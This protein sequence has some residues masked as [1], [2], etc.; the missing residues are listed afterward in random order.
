MKERN[1][2][3]SASDNS[4]PTQVRRL[5]FQCARCGYGAVSAAAPRRC[6]MCEEDVWDL[7][8]RRLFAAARPFNNS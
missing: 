7:A 2:L 3:S 6:P 4:G 8:P 5:N 1:Q